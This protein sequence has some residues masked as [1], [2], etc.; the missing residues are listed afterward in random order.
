ML[1]LF[2]CPLTFLCSAIDVTILGKWLSSQI[3]VTIDP[4]L[5]GGAA[6]TNAMKRSW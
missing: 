5:T 2:V 1:A 6:K 3:R 4:V